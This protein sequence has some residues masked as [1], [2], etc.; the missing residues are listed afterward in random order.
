MVPRVKFLAGYWFIWILFFEIARFA[1]I[2]FNADHVSQ[3]NTADIA[4]T[5]I[6]GF[7]MDASMVS[8][9]IT[10][11]CITLLLALFFEFVSI[12]RILPI[13]TAII[14][15]P[16]ILLVFCDVPAFKAWGYRMDASPLKYLTSPKEA[17]ASVSHL[18]V[19]WI[20]FFFCITY[21]FIYKVFQYYINRQQHLITATVKNKIVA[22]LLFFIFTALQIIPIRGGLQLAPINQSSVY[23]S[24]NNFLNLAAINVPWNFMHSLSQ[25]INSTTNPFIYLTN[26]E[27]VRLK[28]DLLSDTG[29]IEKIIDLSVTPHPNIIMIVWES[30]TQKAIDQYKNGVCITPGFNE[31][32]KEG[33]Y[34][35]NIYATGDRTDKGIVA[36]LSGY[37]SQPTTSIIKIP[38]KASKLPTITKVLAAQDYHSAFYYGGEL[39]FAN[40][41]AYLMG[42]GYDQ[43]TSINNFEEKDLSS[44][45]GAYDGVVKEKILTDL[46]NQQAPFFTTWLTLSSHEPFETPV[47]KVIKGDDEESL[48]LNS[49]HYTDQVVTDFI[50]QCKKQAFW[51][52]TLIVIVADHGHPLPKTSQKID[53]FKIPL[54]ILGGALTKKGVQNEKI[55]SQ[56][57]IA[58]TLL[59]QIGLPKNEFIWSKNLLSSDVKNWAYFSFNNG[60]G[61]IDPANDFIFD[62][63]GK[64]VIERKGPLSNNEIKKGQSLEQ[65][66][67]ADFL[68]K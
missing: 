29:S 10:P 37:P 51:K 48:F 62:N 46:S 28:K 5:F 15:L 57:D 47:A 31:L 19:F 68:S 63:V 39:E 2:V 30:F 33:Y 23:F 50:E 16:I 6:Y 45:W 40:M 32:K 58:S 27:A 25:D 24:N 20:L 41:K 26:Q 38:Q 65:L 49:L 36:V 7:R 4:Q 66:S 3:V 18:P 11:I 53:N 35:S 1:F 56:I 13:Y 59:S 44:K 54:L 64:Q 61:F 22:A 60:F 17:W 43:Y 52:N 14:L 34:F 12:K 42:C 21:Y 55:G 9:I 8:Y 67:F